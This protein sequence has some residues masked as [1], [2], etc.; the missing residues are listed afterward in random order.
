MSYIEDNNDQQYV[1]GSGEITSSK[2]ECTS[3]DQNINVDNITEDLNSVVLDDMSVCAN[4][5]KEGKNGDMNNC[6]KCKSVKYCNAACKKKHRTKHKK[7]CERRVA[8]L[9]EEKQE[10]PP[11]E[12]CPICLVPLPITANLS[13]F[14]SC[15]GKVVCHGCIY[16]MEMASGGRKDLCAFCRKPYTSSYDEEIERV[17]KLMERGNGMAFYQLGGCYANGLYDTPQDYQKAC[18]LW[19]KGGELG[20]A[21]AYCNLG[22]YYERGMGGE[23]YKKKAKYYFE[24]AAMGGDVDARS[25]L[26]RDEYRSGNQQRA[27]KHWII[28]ARAGEKKSLDVIKDL[29]MHGT[30]AKDE[31]ASTLRAYHERQKEMKSDERDKAA[32]LR[33]TGQWHL[34]SKLFE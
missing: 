6:N 32:F 11:N 22:M 2:E 21:T 28:A 27:I 30:V 12:E 13:S 10:H 8:E 33:T 1:G 5:G 4:C 26:G 18:Q 15:C 19:L 23:A 14:Q 24:L 9:H 31:Y 25:F 3:C 20:C 29:F 17:N 34:T 7:A 16:A